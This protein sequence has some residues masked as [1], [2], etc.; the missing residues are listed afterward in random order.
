MNCAVKP[1]NV[2]TPRKKAEFTACL[3]NVHENVR[4]KNYY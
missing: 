4:V 1:L 2:F 3:F